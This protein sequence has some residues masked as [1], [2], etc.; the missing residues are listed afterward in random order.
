M[1]SSRDTT[2]DEA[3]A[4]L[5]RSATP[6]SGRH[7]MPA[8]RVFLVMAVCLLV[9]ALLFAPELKRASERQP[10]GLR[11]TV[12]LA[13]LSPL[14]AISDFVRLSDV[15]AAVQRALGRDSQTWA[16]GQTIFGG[17]D[18]TTTSPAASPSE[19][20]HK[21]GSAGGSRDTEIREPTGADPLRV[22]VVGDSLAD[23]VGFFAERVFKPFF[24][25]VS[26]QGQI[27]TGL[28]RLDYYDWFARMQLI[29]DQY[30]PD[31]TI[32][33]LG[34]NDNQSLQSTDGRVETP[35]GT[36]EWAG[37]YETRVE[38]F[39]RIATSMG[40]HVIWVGLPNEREDDRWEFI[41][42]QNAIFADVA[43]RLP[44]ASYFDTWNTFAAPDGGY[45][46]YYRD[47]NKVELVRADDGVHFNPE[48]YTLLAE[49]VASLATQD[50]GLDP[51]TYEG[52]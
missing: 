41:Q 17:E 48:G 44:N 35:I 3:D 8:G 11:R 51:K 21:D 25:D 13:V 5:D 12:S 1:R 16:G 29:V 10:L 30:R 42:R 47:G 37:A 45:T 23:G 27:S 24:V 52:G 49:K 46:A 36:L 38:Q 4:D 22:V 2:A 31:L 34:E 50:F 32:V 19:R 18:L 20:P 7:G 33:M 14:A 26:R 39:A 15:T 43:A 9:W 40:G 28:A 6:P